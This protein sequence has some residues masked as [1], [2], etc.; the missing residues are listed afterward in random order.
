MIYARGVKDLLCNPRYWAGL[1]DQS[2]DNMPRVWDPEQSLRDDDSPSLIL[3]ASTGERIAHW[4]NSDAFPICRAVRLA[5]LRSIAI[6]GLRLTTC[7][8][9]T[10]R[11]H[12]R[13]E[14]SER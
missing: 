5:N 7:P 2:I 3:D 8:T 6:A 10:R 14:R 12:L 13:S 11:F 4:S 9:P 1:T